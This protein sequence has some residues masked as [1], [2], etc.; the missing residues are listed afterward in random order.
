MQEILKN[1]IDSR[2]QNLLE[3]I[4]VNYPDKF[5]KEHID[6]E[7]IYIKKHIVW[8]TKTENT[9]NT[10][11]ETKEVKKTNETKTKTNTQSNTQCSGRVWSDY[12]FSKQIMKK[13]NDINDKFKVVDFIDLDIKDFNNK[14]VIGKRCCN[15][16]IQNG[17]YCKMHSKHLIHG[18]YLES[19]KKELCYHFIKDGKYL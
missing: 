14:Y 12:I 5:K 4:N 15:N 2:I 1:I 16:K 11:K 17:K 13:L 18:D 7:I 9:E 10:V 6:K 19:P 8:K 3:I